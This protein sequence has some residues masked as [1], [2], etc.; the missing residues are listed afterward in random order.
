MRGY[1]TAN[2]Q[3]YETCGSPIANDDKPVP[4]RPSPEYV[5]DSRLGRWEFW[6]PKAPG[7]I[8]HQYPRAQDASRDEKSTNRA[9][10]LYYSKFFMEIVILLIG[11]LSAWYSMKSD[12]EVTRLSV[13]YL[14]QQVKELKSDINKRLDRLEGKTKESEISW[15]KLTGQDP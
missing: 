9:N 5:W 11:G 15:A 8:L 4:L 13:E 10:L 6:S 12:L 1:L 3:Y 2:G 7:H 14:S